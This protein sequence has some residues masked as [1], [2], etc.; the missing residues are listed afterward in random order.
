MRP[1][2]TTLDLFTGIGGL[3]LATSD[4]G[5][6][7]AFCEKDEACRKVLARHWPDVPIHDD[8]TTLK[9]WDVGPIDL[10]CAGFPCQDVSVAGARSGL[11]GKRTTLWSEVARLAGETGAPFV[12]L[13]N[14]PGLLTSDKGAFLGLILSDLHGLGYDVAWVEVGARDVGA[15]HR[16]LRWFALAWKRGHPPTWSVEHDVP[17]SQWPP[18][19]AE[20]EAWPTPRETTG[21]SSRASMTVDGHWGAPSL[22]QVA[23]LASGVMPR[24]FSDESELTPA[25]RRVWDSEAVRWPPPPSEGETWPTPRGVDSRTSRQPTGRRGGR[26]DFLMDAIDMYWPPGPSDAPGWRDWLD[27]GGPAPALPKSDPAGCVCGKCRRTQRLKMLGNSCIPAQAREALRRLVEAARAPVGGEVVAALSDADGRWVTGQADLFG[28][29]RLKWP[30]GATMLD[31][32]VRERAC[33]PTPRFAA[34]EGWPTPDASAFTKQTGANQKAPATIRDAVGAWA[35]N[36]YPTPS[37]TPYGSS[38]NGVNR[39]PPSG[40]TPSLQ[41][42]ARDEWGTPTAHERTHSP[43]DVHHGKQLANDVD[44]WSTPRTAQASMYAESDEML[45][46]RGRDGRDTLAKQADRWQTPTVT[47]AA[48]RGYT[49]PNGDHDKPFLTLPGQATAWPTPRTITGGA[50]SGARKQELGRTDSGGGDLQA[51]AQN[52]PTPTVQDGCN[53]AGPSQWD[54]NTPP[55]NVEAVRF[56]GTGTE[57]MRLSPTFVE[58]LQGFSVGWTLACE[59]RR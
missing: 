16:R 37:A 36:E 50:E 27:A 46:A 52:W 38:Q 29:Y 1:H 4:L 20:G 25:A 56:A 49:Y 13:E 9:W 47:D 33:A 8:V 41:T 17:S 3:A 11:A 40:H 22:E 23:E 32:V 48:G 54:R 26:P 59:G 10:I 53:T 21:R 18:P 42:W 14:V 28:E 57:P 51:A 34:Y 6:H 2:I 31:G 45:A 15:P 12:F 43:R 44:L 19:P 55:L 58:A 5:R 24:E 30:R 7:V 35:R 39:H